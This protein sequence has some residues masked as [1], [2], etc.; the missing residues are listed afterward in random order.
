MPHCNTM[1]SKVDVDPSPR[2]SPHYGT[3]S[4]AGGFQDAVREPPA[5]LD[6]LLSDE[7]RDTVRDLAEQMRESGV[8]R[9]KL[10]REMRNGKLT[11]TDSSF[12]GECAPAEA[13]RY[14]VFVQCNPAKC[15]P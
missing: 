4:G 6:D 8:L 2:E 15:A 14:C 7:H 11:A 3:F 5:S 13:L 1:T 9:I 10:H 12:K